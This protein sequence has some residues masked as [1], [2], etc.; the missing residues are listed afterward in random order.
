MATL[1]KAFALTVTVP[2][3]FAPFAGAVMETEG[4]VVS[5]GELALPMEAAAVAAL[6]PVA[7]SPLPPHAVVTAITASVSSNKSGLAMSPYRQL[8]E[9]MII[10]CEQHL[11]RDWL[12]SQLVAGERRRLRMETGRRLHMATTCH[13]L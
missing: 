1:S 9:V 5:G 10:L 2:K 3:T 13:Q 4:G 6:V 8:G 12:R 11:T 7:T